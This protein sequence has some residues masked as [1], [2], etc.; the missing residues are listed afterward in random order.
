MSLF[1]MQKTYFDIV[2]IG[3]GSGGLTSAVGLAKA[4]KQ[5]LLV[6]REHL[7]GECT[8]TGCIPSKALL[9][10][11][12]QFWLAKRVSGE[13]AMGEVY[14]REALS[15][16]KSKIAGI[17]EHETPDHFAKMGIVVVMGEAIFTG[18]QTVQVGD[19]TYQFGRAIIATGSSPRLVPIKGLAP[20]H[21]LTNQNIFNL[22]ALPAR[23]LIIG[24]GPIGLELGQACAM[25][26]CQVTIATIDSEIGRL[27]D[28]AIRPHIANACRDLGIKL[29]YSAHIRAVENGLALFDRKTDSVV[30]ETFSVPFDK[31]LIAIGRVPNIPPGL[32]VAEITHTPPGITVD[33]NYRTSNRRVYALGDVADRLKFT[34]MADTV[35]RGVVK[36]ILSYGILPVRVGAIPKVTYLEPEIGQVGMGWGEAISAFGTD[37]LYRLEVPLARLDRAVTDEATDGVLIVIAKRLTGKIIG[38]HM[39][40]PRAGEI[41]ALFTLAIDNNISLWR[42]GRTTYAYPTYAQLAKLAATTFLATQIRHLKADLGQILRR[43][44]LKIILVLIWIIALVWLFDYLAEQNL[45]PLALSLLLFSFFTTTL[46]GPVLFLLIYA[47]RPLTF[48]PATALSILAGTFFGFW[49]GVIYTIIGANAGATIAYIIGRFFSHKTP[50]TITD[51]SLFSRFTD[52]CRTKPFQSILLM[53]LLFLPYDLV[54]YGAGILRVPYLAFISATIVGTILGTI[55]F[56]SLGAAVSTEELLTTGI[57]TSVVDLNFILLSGGIF[58]LSLIISRLTSRY[59]RPPT[60]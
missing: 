13:T 10:H 16:V 9:H 2:V 15:Y 46:W 14:R 57:T 20:E 6:E 41:I 54:N 24:G 26:G 22:P 42:L 49:W 1:I 56:V 4:G 53:R 51:T 3:A 31:T 11:A 60:T 35:A 36:H 18:P 19:V 12:K 32:A 50:A 21:T 28:T 40:G 37:R 43:H 47:L 33:T 5:V 8:N 44:S 29:Q 52:L 39:A 38:A 25:L 45:T 48:L 7:G 59:S 27:E 30:T 23:L 17:L 34:H 55:M 58:L